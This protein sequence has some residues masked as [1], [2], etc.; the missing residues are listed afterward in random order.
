MVAD[1]SVFPGSLQGIC[2]I[3]S[4]WRIAEGVTAAVSWSLSCMWFVS[5]FFFLLM[6]L[7]LHHSGG[8]RT[9][10]V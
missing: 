4:V 6:L 5:F 9:E 3:Y 2:F 1:I 8:G 10:M 7:V